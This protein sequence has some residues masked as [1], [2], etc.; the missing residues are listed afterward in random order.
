LAELIPLILNIAVM[1]K[2]F[3]KIINWI[4]KRCLAKPFNLLPEISMMQDEDTLV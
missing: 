1:K 4:G 3:G 2:P